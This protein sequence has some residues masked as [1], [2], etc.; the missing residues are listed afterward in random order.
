MGCEMPH[1]RPHTCKEC[2]IKAI[3]PVH[4]SD[5]MEAIDLNCG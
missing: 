3:L 2:L 5:R 1:D 4:A